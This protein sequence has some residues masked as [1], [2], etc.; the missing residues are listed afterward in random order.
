MKTFSQYNKWKKRDTNCIYNMI[1]ILKIFNFLYRK[2]IKKIW[3]SWDDLLHLI[4]RLTL[5]QKHITQTN[6]Q[7]PVGQ[8][9]E[10]RNSPVYTQLH[11]HTVP[12]IHRCTHTQFHAHTD[13]TKRHRENWERDFQS[14]VQGWLE[15]KPR[16]ENS[17]TSRR[18]NKRLS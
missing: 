11:T 8:R 3:T 12:H 1:P 4:S 15:C 16:C 6:T 17:I 13:V 2:Q 7:R 14:V 18:Q 9:R 5:K 10:S